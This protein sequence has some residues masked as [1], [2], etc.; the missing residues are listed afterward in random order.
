[1]QFGKYNITKALVRDM[2]NPQQLH[3]MTSEISKSPNIPSLLTQIINLDDEF[4]STN[5]FEHDYVKTTATMPEDKAFHERGEN[6]DQRKTVDTKLF[7]VPS[8]GIQSHIRPTDLKRTRKA[9]TESDLERVETL[10]NEDLAGMRTSFAL[11]NERAI[12]HLITTGTSYVPNGTAPVYDFYAEYAGLTAATRP[13]VY[14]DL[15]NASAYPAEAGEDAR[16][17]INDNLLDGQTVGGYICLCG[18]NFFKSRVRHPKEE[19]AVVDRSG[20]MGQD[21]LQKRLADYSQ[22]YRMYMGADDVLYVQYNASIGGSPLI[23]DNEAYMI[24]A[25]TMGLIK[26]VYAP[27]ETMQYVD[28]IAQ[29]EYAWRM[30]DEF[31]G[32]HLFM[33][34]NSGLFLVNPLSVIKCSSAASA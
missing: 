30:D 10:I 33:E 21:P 19:Q 23:A 2:A 26:R 29:R 18:K 5:I 32:T 25:E 7:K 12:A 13:V 20:A 6:F 15:S 11:L 31:T 8:W 34:S 16:A 27:A 28:T 4:L 9:G 3:D 1:M 22:Q 14:F 17:L 24:P